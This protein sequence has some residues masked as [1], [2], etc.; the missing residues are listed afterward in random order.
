MKCPFCAKDDTAVLESRIFEEG[1][2]IRRRREC[3]KCGKRFTT[4][5]SVRGSTLWVI[6]K[7]GRREVFDREKI[8]RGIL[9]STEKRPISMG[10]I[11]QIVEEV[12]R[13]MLRK[14][15]E[16]VSSKAIGRSIMARLKKIDKVAW[17]RFASVYLE[18]EDLADFEKVIR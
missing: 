12:E 9:R 2:G 7:D 16:E 17:L 5:E 4:Y 13:E 15:S 18:F 10:L 1:K 11:D 6:K 8:K 3:T 14:E